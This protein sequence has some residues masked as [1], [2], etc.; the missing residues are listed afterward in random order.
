MD[1]TLLSA[2]PL[3]GLK[4]DAVGSVPRVVSTFSRTPRGFE[5]FADWRSGW[6]RRSFG[7][8]VD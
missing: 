7:I 8:V 3:V 5:A 6:R 1:G 4:P 2:E